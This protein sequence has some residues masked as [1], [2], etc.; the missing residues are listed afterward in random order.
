VL[1]AR[2]LIFDARRGN[3]MGLRWGLKWGKVAAGMFMVL[4]GSQ[5]LLNLWV[6]GRF[7]PWGFAVVVIGV[8]TLII[9]LMGE[10]G[11]W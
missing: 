5:I 10:D 8:Y 1:R 7:S 6:E 3:A 2:G 9:G 4:T 11:V